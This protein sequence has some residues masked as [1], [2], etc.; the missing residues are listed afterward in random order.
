MLVIHGMLAYIQ[1]AKK[2][3]V[4]APIEDGDLALKR[5]LDENQV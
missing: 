2:V 5:R 3:Y 4:Y 1:S